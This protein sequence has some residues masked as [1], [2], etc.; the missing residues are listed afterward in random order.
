LV[1]KQASVRRRSY[2]LCQRSSDYCGTMSA[3]APVT[4]D[5][6]RLIV[7]RRSEG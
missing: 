6:G 7:R 3:D 4:A 2:G 1:T 5:R